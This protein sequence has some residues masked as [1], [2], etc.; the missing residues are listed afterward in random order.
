MV[1][2]HPDPLAVLLH[3][4][5]DL[6]LLDRRC[7]RRR[8]QSWRLSPS[9]MTVSGVEAVDDRGEAF[10]ASRACRRAAAAGRARRRPSPSPGAGRRRSA[11]PRPASRARPTGRRRSV[12]PQT[13]IG[14]SWKSS[15]RE[16]LRLQLEHCGL[17][18][19]SPRRSAPAA[20]SRS[21]LLARRA[22]TPPPCR[23]RAGSAPTAAT[24]LERLMPDSALDAAKEITEPRDVQEPCGR[25][26]PRCLEQDVVRVVAAQHVVDEVGG[27]GDLAAG[28]LAA[29]VA[30]LDQ[31]GDD[32]AAWRNVRFIRL[33]SAS[34]ASRS[35]PSMSSVEQ[36][37]EIERAARRSA[38]TYRRAPHGQP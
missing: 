34:Q 6:E 37:R 11:R 10:A 5:Q 27:D 30:P 16:A 32:R 28:L 29:R 20:A 15:K 14:W 24:R 4:L 35:S 23:S 2:G 1:A 8:P 31:A 17:P 36:L 25:I 19:P 18:S 3:D 33:D 9:A 26:G 7:A 38:R 13:E 12:L 22:P 21:R